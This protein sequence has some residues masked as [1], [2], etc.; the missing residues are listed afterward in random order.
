MAACLAH[1]EALAH[2]QAQQ[3]TSQL[4][5]IQACL[6]MNNLKIKTYTYKDIAAARVNHWTLNPASSPDSNTIMN[7]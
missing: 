2:K 5:V 6:P 7:I 3:L 1:L 4:M